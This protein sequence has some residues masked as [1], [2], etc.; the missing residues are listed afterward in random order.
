MNRKELGV[1]ILVIGIIIIIAAI[2][3]YIYNEIRVKDAVI[4]YPMRS[5]AAYRI[6]INYD[7]FS[8]TANEWIYGGEIGGMFNP[9]IRDTSGYLIVNKGVLYNDLS[10]DQRYKN[11]LTMKSDVEGILTVYIF[12]GL[13]VLSLILGIMIKTGQLMNLT[14]KNKY[15]LTGK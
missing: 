13:G 11:Y 4:V 15:M 12:T 10:D 2:S 9:E 7:S 8:K 3:Y 14:Y 1:G 5:R 6:P